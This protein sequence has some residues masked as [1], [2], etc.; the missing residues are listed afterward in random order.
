MGK[1]KTF[2][3]LTSKQKKEAEKYWNDIVKNSGIKNRQK[4]VVKSALEAVS[5]VDRE[6]IDRETLINLFQSEPLFNWSRVADRLKPLF[7]TNRD[8]RKA[9]LLELL[10]DI[11]WDSNVTNMLYAGYLKHYFWKIFGNELNLNEAE[12]FINE[13][14]LDQSGLSEIQVLN[15]FR[16][17]S[18][19]EYYS[20]INPETLDYEESINFVKEM[21][22]H[23]INNIISKYQ[24]V[25]YYGPVGKRYTVPF[26]WVS[27]GF[28]SQQVHLLV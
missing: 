22:K 23:D 3:L 24:T 7:V 9:K 18:I 28:N 21:I 12:E 10:S 20:L 17:K 13:Y 5:K 16:L 4:Q 14:I 2:S 19:I 26:A 1:E 15:L 27:S 11:D 25:I 8:Q 6:G